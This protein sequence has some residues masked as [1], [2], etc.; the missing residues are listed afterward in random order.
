MI[1]EGVY[2][3]HHGGTIYVCGSDKKPIIALSPDAMH[4]FVIQ[5]LDAICEAKGREPI[6]RD[7]LA[8]LLADRIENNK[9]T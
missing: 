6:A 2:V 8:K 3:L 1:N 7:V 5:A 9:V 4:L